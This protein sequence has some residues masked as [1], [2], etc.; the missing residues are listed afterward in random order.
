VL[1]KSACAIVDRP[2]VSDRTLREFT[3]C[4]KWRAAAAEYIRDAAPALVVVGSAGSYPFDTDTWRDG[5]VD[6][7]RS[8][9]APGRRIAVLGP[10][11]VLPFDAPYCLMRSHDQLPQV[12]D[13]DECSVPLGE[14]AFTGV[15]AALREAVAQVSGAAYIDAAT[16]AC[17]EGRCA[18]WRGGQ[19]A[20]RDNQHLNARYVESLAP[21]LAGLLAPS[22]AAPDPATP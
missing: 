20:F 16:L 22:M 6:F 14:V 19:L 3:E 7:L 18:A 13:L 10:T 15:E 12:P 2:F 9:A 21:G 4:S 11:P 8:I 5:S 17:P 1:T